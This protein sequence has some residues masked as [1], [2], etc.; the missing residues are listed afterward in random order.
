MNRTIH[1][2][3]PS[4]AKGEPY[5]G[6]SPPDEEEGPDREELYQ[7]FLAWAEMDEEEYESLPTV[8]KDGLWDNFAEFLKHEAEMERAAARYDL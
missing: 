4:Y 8:Y 2:T 1:S 7:D 5:H 3:G 6:Y